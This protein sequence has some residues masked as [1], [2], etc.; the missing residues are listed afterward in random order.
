MLKLFEKQQGILAKLKHLNFNV[1][2]VFYTAH[3]EL[4]SVE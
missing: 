2:C 3:V 4:S 1:H